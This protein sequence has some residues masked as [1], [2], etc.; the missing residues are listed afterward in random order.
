MQGVGQHHES[1]IE[2]GIQDQIFDLIQ[3]EGLFGGLIEAVL[4]LDHEGEVVVG[5]DLQQMGDHR[6]HQHEDHRAPRPRDADGVVHPGEEIEGE[7]RQGEQGHENVV[8]EAHALMVLF[9][10]FARD[11]CAR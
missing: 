2:D 5:G 6:E 4:L 3:P 11:F 9:C 8:V 7:D 10:L 1:G